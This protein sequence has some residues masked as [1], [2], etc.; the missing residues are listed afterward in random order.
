MEL[1]KTNERAVALERKVENLEQIFNTAEKTIIEVEKSEVICQELDDEFLML[2]ED[3]QIVRTTI[4]STIQRAKNVL[5]M[6]STN[7]ELDPTASGSLISS[8]SELVNSINNSGKLLGDLYKT[9]IDIKQKS[10]SQL[11]N[12]ETAKKDKVLAVSEIT[13][14][15]ANSEPHLLKK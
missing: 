3:F 10:S 13:R 5:D 2:K 9:L 4:L 12:N 15:I 6:L 1:T 14:L 11:E 7:I 8:Y